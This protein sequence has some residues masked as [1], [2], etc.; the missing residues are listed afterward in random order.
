MVMRLNSVRAKGSNNPNGSYLVSDYG[1]MQ[2]RIKAARW[3]YDCFEKWFLDY[4]IQLDWQSVA[5][6]ETPATEAAL[7]KQLSTQQAKV[8]GIA[9]AMERL[10]KLASTAD[11]PPKTLMNQMFQLENER[12]EADRELGRLETE[13]ESATVRHNA[14]HE[15]G[16]Q[17][18][19][20]AVA[21]DLSTRMRLREEIR[22]RVSRIDLFPTGIPAKELAESPVPIRPEMP[23]FRITFSNGAIRWVYCDR[24]KPGGDA[25]LMDA[26]PARHEPA[27][28]ELREQ[29]ETYYA[30]A[31][32]RKGLCKQPPKKLRRSILTLVWTKK[33]PAVRKQRRIS[34]T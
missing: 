23:G 5:N 26:P 17:I 31:R 14:I 30:E 3:R 21:D 13:V 10:A 11:T 20:L 19:D 15:T 18:R 6:E 4:V 25:S 1:R 12:Q 32:Q 29:P 2:T 24:R 22:R 16:S 27:E 9:Q 28:L 7:Q 33:R 34:K 8:E